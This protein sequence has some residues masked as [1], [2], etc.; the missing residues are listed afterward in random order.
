MLLCLYLIVWAWIFDQVSSY[1]SQIKTPSCVG[2]F[3]RDVL[4]YFFPPKKR[5]RGGRDDCSL[6]F[7]CGFSTQPVVI[8]F[9]IKT[10]LLR[11]RPS[12]VVFKI[13]FL[14]SKPAHKG[15]MTVDSYKIVLFLHRST[16]EAESFVPLRSVIPVMTVSRSCPYNVVS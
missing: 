11:G 15:G 13:L 3:V 4:A 5:A 1:S 8:P 12:W 6:Q 14:P 7:G 9:Q 16:I 10:S 2:P